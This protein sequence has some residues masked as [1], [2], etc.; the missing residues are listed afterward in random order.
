MCLKINYN[1]AFYEKCKRKLK[2]N[3]NYKKITK[4]LRIR[5]ECICIFNRVPVQNVILAWKLIE[6]V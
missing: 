1:K 5:L 4:C 2:I 3:N 6:R